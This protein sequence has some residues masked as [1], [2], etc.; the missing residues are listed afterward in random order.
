MAFLPWFIT[1]ST[2]I[3]SRFL[4]SMGDSLTILAKLYISG[5]GSKF[6]KVKL[7]GLERP[8]FCTSIETKLSTYTTRIL[9]IILVTS[10]V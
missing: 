3:L 5:V 1:V 4:I 9:S 8:P 10:V 6:Q 2:D 7:E